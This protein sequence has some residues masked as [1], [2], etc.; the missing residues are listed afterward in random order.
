MSAV[1]PVVFALWHRRLIPSTSP[2]FIA[3]VTNPIFESMP[4]WD[5]L[6]NIE[7]GKISVN[8]DI[9]TAAPPPSLFPSPPQIIP[10]SGTIR[11][12]GSGFED[13]AGIGRPPGQKEGKDTAGRDFVAKSDNPDNLFMEDVRI[14]LSPCC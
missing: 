2:D 10:R 12:D 1:R 3:G 13:D 4:I 5:V 6:C 7:T 11:S 9:R 14:L 8:K